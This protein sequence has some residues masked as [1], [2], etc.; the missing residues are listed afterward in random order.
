VAASGKV[1]A[2][3]ATTPGIATGA[4]AACLEGEARRIKFPRHTDRELRFS[5]PLVYKKSGE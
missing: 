2:A 1:T 4:L 5:F 3:T